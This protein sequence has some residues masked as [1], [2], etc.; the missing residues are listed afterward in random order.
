MSPQKKKDILNS[1]SKLKQRVIWKWDEELDV[2][3]DKF[4]IRNWLPQVS[5][6]YN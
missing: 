6:L 1:L 3:K 2:D 4:L 5:Y